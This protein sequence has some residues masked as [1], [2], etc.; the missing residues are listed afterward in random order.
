MIWSIPPGTQRVP[1][2]CI[3]N[4]R[5]HVPSSAGGASTHPPF[6]WLPCLFNPG[7][8][9]TLRLRFLACSEWRPPVVPSL[10]L[11]LVPYP[12][13]WSPLSTTPGFISRC[14]LRPPRTLPC[15]EKWEKMMEHS[16]YDWSSSS[17]T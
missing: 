4:D 8:L 15:P 17:C 3:N 12:L 5:F 16:E 1:P 9:F 7:T 2:T 11:P 13:V 10:R 6:T 14:R